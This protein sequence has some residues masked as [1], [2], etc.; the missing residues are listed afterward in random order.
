M[1]NSIT[2]KKFGIIPQKSKQLCKHLLILGFVL[3]LT[4]CY[5]SGHKFF[6]MYKYSPQ[7]DHCEV[8]WVRSYDNAKRKLDN[9]LPPVEFLGKSSFTTARTYNEQAAQQDCMLAGGDYIIVIDEGFVGSTQSQFTLQNTKTYTANNN[10][11]YYGSNGGYYGRSNS[12]TTYQVPTYQ[13]YNITH[14]YYGFSYFVYKRDNKTRSKKSRNSNRGTG[15]S[16]P[17]YVEDYDEDL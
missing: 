13:T 6:D 15:K 11:S 16:G 2:K 14:N 9:E 8:I 5:A 12:T 4:G 17:R 10:T 3:I 1:T 7:T